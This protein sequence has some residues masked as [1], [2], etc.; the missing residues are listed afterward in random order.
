MP[1]ST[2]ADMNLYARSIFN[3]AN[4]NVQISFLTYCIYFENN[5]MA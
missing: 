5:E 4:L 3:I 1:L 2:D